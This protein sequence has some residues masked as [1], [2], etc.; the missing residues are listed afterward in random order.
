[1][2]VTT[3][4]ILRRSS[5][6]QEFVDTFKE[7]VL[8]L[9]NTLLAL[10]EG[11]LCFTVQAQTTLALEELWKTYQDGTLQR[12]LQEFLI[13]EE[14]KRLVGSEVKLTVTIDEQE[15]KNAGWDL[16]V[17]ETQGNSSYNPL[18]IFSRAIY[19]SHQVMLP[20]LN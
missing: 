8:P 18:H 2:V 1:M 10:G 4:M 13:T 17:S 20:S 14:I 7:T 6:L 15:Y 11:S 5:T 16:I 9:G 3:W 19:W 12:K